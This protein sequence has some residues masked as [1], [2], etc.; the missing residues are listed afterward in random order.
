[1]AA[2]ASS[3]SIHAERVVLGD[4]LT[5]PFLVVPASIEVT[6]QRITRVVEQTRDVWRAEVT[7]GIGALDLGD[8]VVAPAFID[9]H[10]HVSMTAFRGLIGTDALRG[11]VVEDLFYRLE[12]ALTDD[13]IRAF[14]RVG[15]YECLA[16][17]VALVWDH[18]Y[19]STALA[20]GLADAGI[21]AVVAPTLQDLHGPGA[22]HTERQL[23]ATLALCDPAWAARG[24][25]PALGPHATD[26]VSPA[27]WARVAEISRARSLP[28]HAHV[29]QSL[30]EYERSFDRHGCSPVE[31]LRRHGVL[32]A[33]RMLLVHAIFVSD[34]DLATLD[35]D[36][37]VLGYC[38]LSQLQF[39]FPAHVPSW[40]ARG[41]PWVVGTDCAPSNDALNVQREL[42]VVAGTRGFAAATSAAYAAFR[43]RASADAARAVDEVRVRELEKL[44]TLTDPSFLLSRVWSIPGGMH[45]SV[46]AGVIAPGALANLQVLDPGHPAMWPGRD[47]IRTLAMADTSPALERLLVAGQWTASTGTRAAYDATYQD[48]RREADRRLTLH[49]QRLGL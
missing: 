28:I 47:V 17:G 34:D 27:L 25:W 40:T 41:L 18:Y 30:Q 24:V 12:A 31:Q 46:R 20:E 36:R 4:G 26:T 16:H 2:N 43:A 45:P 44:G 15:A 21:G 42:P 48:A 39:C 49:L 29:A 1:M 19:G 14:V 38:P 8:R 6:G 22:Q 10:T 13:D 33:D 32:D 11:N 35:P 3:L 9:A 23:E 7:P 37:H 5:T